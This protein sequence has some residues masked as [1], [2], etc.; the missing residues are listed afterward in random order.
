MENTEFLTALANSLEMQPSDINSEFEL[1]GKDN[2]D[3]LMLLSTISTIDKYF[4][5]TVNACELDNC[6]NVGALCE[7]IN[8]KKLSR[9][10][11]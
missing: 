8:K 10:P 5:L 2:W 6:K 3:S 9:C 1:P 7:L 11:A 4:N